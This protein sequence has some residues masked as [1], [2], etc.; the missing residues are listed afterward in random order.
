MWKGLPFIALLALAAPAL[1]QPTA[2]ADAHLTLP[3]GLCRTAIAIAEQTARIPAQ[4]LAAIARVESGRFDPVANRVNPWP[5]TINAEGRSMAFETKSQA[6]AAVE[7]LQ[8]QGMRSIDVGCVQ[9]NLMHHPQAF[10]S[11]DQ[12][13]DPLVNARYAAQFLTQL[14]EKMGDWI[15][16]T[17]HYHSA[18]PEFGGAYQ[19]KVI[20]A[21][22]EEQR[23]ALSSRVIGIPPSSGQIIAPSLSK[24][25][26]PLPSLARPVRLTP[27]QL[28]RT[29]RRGDRS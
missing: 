21:W 17:A 29:P 12:A 15:Q 3:T 27:T 14:R 7:A 8:A 20:A 24:S 13:F 1:C 11:L 28:I 18:T 22:P 6:I 4:L 9:V 16:A 19:S 10:M 2:R 5:W 26:A 25:G 23:I